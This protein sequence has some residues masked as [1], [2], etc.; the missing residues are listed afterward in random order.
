MKRLPSFAATAPGL[1]LVL[2]LA[3]WALAD[4]GSRG[5]VGWAAVATLATQMPLHFLLRGWRRRADRFVAALAVASAARLLAVAAS[6]VLLAAT[7]FV[8]PAAF[9]LSLAAFLVAT[10]LAE[11]VLE[12]GAAPAP[13]GSA[14]APTRA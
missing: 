5:A 12:Y 11:A 14:R 1:L 9:L 3:A 6:V 13:G 2:V 10:S 8:P 7:A 4:A